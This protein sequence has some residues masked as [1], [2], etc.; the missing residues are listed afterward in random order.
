MSVNISVRER[1]ARPCS[2]DAELASRTEDVGHG[3]VD[4]GAFCIARCVV[5]SSLYEVPPILTDI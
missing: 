1:P 5:N 2:Q 4:N 3:D